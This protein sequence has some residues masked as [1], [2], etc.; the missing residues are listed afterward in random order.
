MGGL[1]GQNAEGPFY[2]AAL[3]QAAAQGNVDPKTH[4][5]LGKNGKWV[6]AGGLSEGGGDTALFQIKFSEHRV[7]IYIHVLDWG[8]AARKHCF[9]AGV[10][11]GWL[12]GQGQHWMSDLINGEGEYTGSTTSWIS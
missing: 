4:G 5:C 3:K 6:E 10:Q 7:L 11:C 8:A 1:R 2:F 9:M 12:I